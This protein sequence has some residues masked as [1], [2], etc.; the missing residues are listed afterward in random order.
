VHVGRWQQ[1]IYWYAWK[2]GP[3]LMG[4]YGSPEFIALASKVATPEGRLL[5]LIQA[6]QKTEDFRGLRDRTRADYIKHI[7][8]IEQKLG[9]MP[10]K[11]LA[12]PRTR[13][14][15]LDWR[16][17]L[18]QSSKRG[19]DYTFS[20]LARSSRPPR[21][22]ARSRSIRA[23]GPGASITARASIPFGARSRRQRFSAR[24]PRT[25]TCRWLWD[26]GPA[27]ARAICCGSHGR[28]MTARIFGC[29]N[30]RPASAC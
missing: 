10:I 26:Y 14:I 5:A 3:R 20:V 1:K 8:K 25:C 13:G 4:E 24:R 11:A 2:N 22:A 16:D 28:P 23:S 27:S 15:L 7:G 21:I 29:G 6:Y 12:D 19:A 30:P 18:A 17:E 9:D